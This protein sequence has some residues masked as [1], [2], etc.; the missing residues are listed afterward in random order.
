MTSVYLDH[1]ATTPLD[2]D[3][4]AVMTAALREEFG[5]PSSVHAPGRSARVRLDEARDRVAAWIKAHPAEIVFTSGGTEADNLA[6]F[7][8]A[9]ALRDRGRHLVTS[10][11]EHPAVLNPCRRLEQEGFQVDYLPVD[12]EGRIDPETLRRSLRDDTLL[13]SIQHANSET[14]VLQ[15][16][17]TLGGIVRERGILFHCDAVQSAGKLE[18]DLGAWPV[19]L[20]SLSAHKMYG[21]KGCGALFI[22]RGTP[23][24]V[25][26]ILGGGQERK[27]RGGTENLPALA[28]FGRAAQLAAERW[29]Q[30][31]R[32][33][34]TLR[35]RLWRG[36]EQRIPEVQFHTPKEESLPNT[37][38]VAFE[39]VAGQSLLIRLDVAGVAVSTGTA[40]SSGVTLPSETLQALGL[41][42]SARQGT[43]RL[44]L[45]RE[46]T[47]AGVDYALEVL[48]EAVKTIR[49]GRAGRTALG[50]GI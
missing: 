46:T 3:V 13:V 20:L 8:V 31:A 41:S 48:S 34:R 29:E 28:G 32:H 26:L 40:C 27:R 22:R 16:I 12:S 7:G 15:D 19:D 17:Q 14:G 36:I 1:N 39:G 30:D 35:D 18:I 47:E 24:L 10:R 45:G 23:P 49:D 9:R 25:P 44:S 37:L 38:S 43:L 2:P 50:T 33:M 4:C 42:E 11:L 5:N 6:L 21:P